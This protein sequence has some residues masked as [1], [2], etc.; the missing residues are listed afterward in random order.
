MTQ[1]GKRGKG[2]KSKGTRGFRRCGRSA[3]ATWRRRAD[4][5]LQRESAAFDALDHLGAIERDGVEELESR[6]MHLEVGRAVV[7]GV[8]EVHQIGPH[9]VGRELG[10]RAAV[11]SGQLADVNY[12]SPPTTITLPHRQ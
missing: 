9:L 1:R 8:D 4:T 10:G 11:V 3:G 6:H 12:I 2:I 5:L 7:E